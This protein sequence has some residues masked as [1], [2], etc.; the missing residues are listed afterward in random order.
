MLPN[1][2]LVIQACDQLGLQYSFKDRNKNLLF[3]ING[4]KHVTFLNSSTSFNNETVAKICKDKSFTYQLLN[5]FVSMPKTLDY[6]DPEVP[7]EF[8]SYV[9]QKNNAEV[10]DNILS[11]FSFPIVLKPNQK[12]HGTNVFKCS[13]KEEVLSAV[14]T[15]FDKKTIDYDYLLLA[16]ECIQSKQEF[17]VITFKGKVEL[18]YL[19]DISEANFSGNLSPLHWEGAKAKYIQD[20]NLIKKI[21][22]FINP[23]FSQI[24]L[25]YSGLDI[26]IDNQDKMW[27]IEL[28]SQPVFR[29]FIEENNKQIVVDMFKRILSNL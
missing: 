14:N 7:V 12:S 18:V 27:L 26:I 17:R 2:S 21:Q 20:N 3:V 28:N 6:L 23:I 24:D 11:N 25:V 19:K 16:Q 10:T 8:K 29:K 13:N 22:E 4:D 9:L 15:I 5:K 1:I